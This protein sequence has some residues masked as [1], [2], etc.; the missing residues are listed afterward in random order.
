VAVFGYLDASVGFAYD[1]VENVKTFSPIKVSINVPLLL[2][3][4][5]IN[6]TAPTVT[7]ELRD[8]KI[9]YTVNGL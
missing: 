4:D 6:G 7:T 2:F 5:W 1:A 3:A 9:E 8:G